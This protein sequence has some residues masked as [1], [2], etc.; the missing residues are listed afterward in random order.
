M[1]T[2]KSQVVTLFTLAVLVAFSG[3]NTIAIAICLVFLG[4]V[5]TF[6]AK[7]RVVRILGMTLMLSSMTYAAII[8]AANLWQLVK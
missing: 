1:S 3:F 6:Y 8:G 5:C 7:S 4:G 2:L